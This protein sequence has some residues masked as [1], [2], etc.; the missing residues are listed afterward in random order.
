[1]AG[2]PDKLIVEGLGRLD[3]EYE[4]DILGL[5]VPGNPECMTTREGMRVQEISGARGGEI[6]DEFLRYNAGVALA[7]AVVIL[8]RKG[9]RPNIDQLLDKQMGEALRF[10]VGTRKTEDDEDDAEG[11]AGPPDE[12]EGTLTPSPDGG[13]SS[14]SPSDQQGNGQKPTGPLGS[15]TP[16]SALA[17]VPATSAT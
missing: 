11:D 7:L 6:L 17:S 1:M 9:K 14:S 4:C 16:T 3:G 8:E 13:T 2:L 15:G 5:T 12:G 10:E